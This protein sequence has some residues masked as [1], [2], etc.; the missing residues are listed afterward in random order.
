MQGAIAEGL[1]VRVQRWHRYQDVAR[2][3]SP[4]PRCARPLSQRAR[5]RTARIAIFPSPLMGE[6]LRVRV[7]NLA[8]Y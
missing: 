8:H 1:R 3:F 4:R 7:K 5:R 2:V 6:G